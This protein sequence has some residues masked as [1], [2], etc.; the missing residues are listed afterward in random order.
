[1]GFFSDLWDTYTQ[2]KQKADEAQH[3]SNAQMYN[4]ASNAAQ[5][6]SDYAEDAITPD[7]KKRR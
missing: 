5:S 7:V 1:M 3:A 4:Y 6:V 2:N